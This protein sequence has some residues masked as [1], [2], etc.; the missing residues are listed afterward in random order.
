LENSR[1]DRTPPDGENT[2]PSL[3]AAKLLSEFYEEEHLRGRRPDSL[4]NLKRSAPR[5]LRWLCTE[6][7]EP[8][9]VTA[10]T[11]LAYQAALLE[12]KKADGAAYSSRTLRFHVDAAAAFCS[13]LKRRGIL[14]ANPFKEIRRVRTE[15]KIPRGLL[16]ETKLDAL[17]DR[18]ARFDEADGIRERILTYRAHVAAEL[19]YA[20]GMRMGEAVLLRPDDLDL[21]RGLVRIREGK[22]GR[23]R[24]AYL[25]SFAV[26]VLR[27]FLE[28]RPLLMTEQYRFH[29]D[30]LFGMARLGFN[31]FLNRRLNRESAA[32]GFG[33]FT[34]H[35]F[36]HCV[37][38]HLLRAGCGMRNIQEILG[39]EAIGST[40]IYTQVDKE[41]L[42]AV[43]DKFH[44]R[45]WR[46][47]DETEGA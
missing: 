29:P 27:L 45:K 18:F 13:F 5:F 34:S 1:D 33:R 35:A 12:S 42:K 44:P 20:T 39:H 16:N 3:D 9:E 22:G 6:G 38:Y 26:Q 4:T 40:E 25:S 37:G 17:L 36:R 19:L 11:A 47:G 30:R 21:D 14:F 10:R 43:L 15:K 8:S 7:I 28:L 32:L 2:T 31:D 23:P 24:D 46:K 41:D